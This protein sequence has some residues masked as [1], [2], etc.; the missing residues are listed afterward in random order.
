MLSGRLGK[1]AGGLTRTV[2]KICQMAYMRML[3]GIFAMTCMVIVCGCADPEPS[4]Y[5]EMDRFNSAGPLLPELDGELIVASCWKQQQYR[6][7]SGDVIEL[8]MPAI[9]KV[10]SSE[11]PGWSGKREPYA[12][13]VNNDGDVFLPVIGAVKAAGLT[14][15]EL[16][17]KIAQSYYPRFVVNY[18]AIVVSVKE[19]RTSRVSVVGA[20]K[21]SGVYELRADEMSL[22]NLL[23]KAGGITEDGA[24]SIRIAHSDTGSFSK[25]II[26]PVKGFNVPF[27][28]AALSNG[29]MVVVEPLLPQN[30]TVVGLVNRPGAFAFTP[31]VNYNVMQAIAHAGG[32]DE[33]AAPKFV[34]VYRQDRDGQIVSALLPLSGREAEKSLMIRLKPGDILAVEQTSRTRTRKLLAEIVQFNLGMQ[35]IYRLDNKDGSN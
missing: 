9:M 18:P 33:V 22:V 19:Y 14:L 4:S 31:G 2:F 24:A 21:T 28:D 27:E 16:E 3:V 11:L 13:R 20:V 35:T 23:M 8:E 34:R 17:S 5:Q 15:T 29:D 26:L 32:L 6:L 10:S 1:E 30:F 12:C 25:P 7:V